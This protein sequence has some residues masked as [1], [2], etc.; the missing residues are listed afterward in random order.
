MNSPKWSNLNWMEHKFRTSVFIE[1]YGDFLKQGISS[2][3]DGRT[4]RAI[5][6]GGINSGMTG[7][8]WKWN[9]R[10]ADH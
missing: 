2:T 3:V 1:N 8:M 4:W 6:D 5:L 10:R 9:Y 7:G